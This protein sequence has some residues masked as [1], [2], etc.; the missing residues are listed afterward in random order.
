M[1]DIVSD[2]D[3]LICNTTRA[4]S[5]LLGEVRSSGCLIPLMFLIRFLI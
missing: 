3:G 2:H 4:P 1:L 5:D